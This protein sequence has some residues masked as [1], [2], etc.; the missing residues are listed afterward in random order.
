MALL[1]AASQKFG[2]N[3]DFFLP[4][5]RGKKSPRGKNQRDIFFKFLQETCGLSLE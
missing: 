1:L 5:F 3:L 4:A 2:K